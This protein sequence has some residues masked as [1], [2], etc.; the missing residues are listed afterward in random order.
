MLKMN[1]HLKPW[2][3]FFLTHT[4]NYLQI[5]KKKENR[6]LVNRT[7]TTT[8]TVIGISFFFFILTNVLFYFILDS[9]HDASAR[10]QGEGSGTGREL[11]SK[12]GMCLELSMS[13]FF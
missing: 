7:T 9:S 5:D 8:T 4:N 12:T 3:F 2:N 10:E 11:W 13:L 6:K 1:L